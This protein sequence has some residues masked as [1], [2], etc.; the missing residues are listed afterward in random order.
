LLELD[1]VVRSSEGLLR[2]LVGNEVLM[3]VSLHGAGGRLLA[4]FT[5]VQQ[6]LLNLAANARDAMPAGGELRI[7]TAAVE[8][9]DQ[10]AGEV[11]DARP[12]P[13]LRLSVSDTGHG[14]DAETRRRIFE[15]FFT[16]KDK[17][18]GTGLGLATVYGI[19]KQGSGWIGVESAPGRGTT[20]HIY[21]PRVE[22]AAAAS[23]GAAPKTA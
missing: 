3:E 5:Q 6:I 20:F 8:W 1:R 17:G 9:D 15:P 11:P 19:V 22:A 21:L 16:T 10:S 2:T 4:D 23:Q 13:A 12:G 14:M 18:Q 7:E